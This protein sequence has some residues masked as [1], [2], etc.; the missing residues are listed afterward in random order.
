MVIR[1]HT[2]V[3]WKVIRS[4]GEILAKKVSYHGYKVSCH[5]YKVAYPSYM[6]SYKITR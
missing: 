6:E 1:L 4:Q 2:L 5:G 3:I